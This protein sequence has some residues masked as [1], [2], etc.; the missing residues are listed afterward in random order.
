MAAPR[1]RDL[2]EE[3]ILEGELKPGERLR[4]EALAQRFGTSRT[5]VREALLQLEAQGLVD[6][7]PNRGAVVRTFDRDDLFDLYQLRALLEP[8]AAALAA[9]R[10]GDG[11][12][13]RL[14]GLCEA[15]DQMVANEAFHRIILEAAGSP[16]L[17]D[18]MRAA[19]G[20]P[21]TFRSVF[22]HDE[23]QRDESLMCH[24]RLVAAFT[25]RDAQ[26]AEAVM[27]MHILG[28]IAFLE[29]Q[30]PSH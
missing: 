1:V 18:A 20:I 12:I 26:L 16:R 29:E 13:E 25:A 30:W 22:W 11:D 17:L 19:T 8:R 2:L 28:A 6:V 21:R 24:R 4:A 7:E 10:I 15:E 3:A 14:A 23:R 27:R 9:P 5:P